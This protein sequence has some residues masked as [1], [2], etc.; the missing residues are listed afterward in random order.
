MSV[1][2]KNIKGFRAKLNDSVNMHFHSNVTS[3]NWYQLSLLLWSRMV[4]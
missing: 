3:T 1:T 4:K 2:S